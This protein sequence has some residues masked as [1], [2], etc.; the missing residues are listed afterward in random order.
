MSCWFPPYI[1]LIQKQQL[2]LIYITVQ[3][4]TER[5]YN[6]HNKELVCKAHIKECE[7]KGGKALGF[8]SYCSRAKCVLSVKRKRV[9][10]MKD[11]TIWMSPSIN[12]QYNNFQDQ[13]NRNYSQFHFQICSYCLHYCRSRLVHSKEMKSP[14]SLLSLGL[15]N[16]ILKNVYK[17]TNPVIPVLSFTS[18]LILRKN[19]NNNNK[20]LLPKFY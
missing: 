7:G 12:R 3:N 1:V 17:F 13:A 15:F 4:K 11:G 9:L 16:S 5:I 10:Q 18:S 2:L 20:L 19:N 14:L 8:L 6:L